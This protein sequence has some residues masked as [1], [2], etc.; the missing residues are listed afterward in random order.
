M[1]IGAVLAGLAVVAVA[2]QL[3]AV[4]ASGEATRGALPSLVGYP[5]YEPTPFGYATVPFG[6]DSVRWIPQLSP[7]VLQSAL[8]ASWAGM[9][10]GAPPVTYTYAPF[11]GPT[12]RLTMT[13]AVV[14]QAGVPDVWWKTQGGL[15]ALGLGIS[16][17]LAAAS[18]LLAPPLQGRRGVVESRSSP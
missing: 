4:G 3:V 2:I 9:K 12:Y 7:I 16:V 5:I 11:Y 18:S 13:H 17:I 8:I 10:L 6:D 1:I 15:G 14:R